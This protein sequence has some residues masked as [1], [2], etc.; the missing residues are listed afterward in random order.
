MKYYILPGEEPFSSGFVSWGN[1]KYIFGGRSL[2][3]IFWFTFGSVRRRRRL[4]EDPTGRS[5]DDIV[6]A[7]GS[8]EGFSFFASRCLQR[9]R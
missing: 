9:S 6:Y 1:G 8:A 2:D 5:A 4:S 3:R 7:S